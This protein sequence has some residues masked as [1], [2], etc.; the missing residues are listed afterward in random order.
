MKSDTHC[1]A[2][3]FA[4]CIFVQVTDSKLSLMGSQ[5]I[6]ISKEISGQLAMFG[7]LNEFDQDGYVI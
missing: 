1:S 2:V 3:L 7:W 5:Q 4:V 6:P